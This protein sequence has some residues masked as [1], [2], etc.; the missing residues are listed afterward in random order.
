MTYMELG[1]AERALLG[2]LDAIDTTRVDVDLFINQHTGELM[3]L[4]PSKIN[5]LPE[6]AEYSCIRRSWKAI[7][8]EGHYKM[9]VLKVLNAIKWKFY[10]KKNHIK[11]DGVST[12]FSMDTMIKYLPSLYYLGEYDLAI[13]FIDPPHIIQD[14]VLA[15]K[16]IEWIHTDFTAF[17]YNSS[18]T[19]SRWAANDYI[20]SISPDI[21]KSFLTLYPTLKDKI[22]EIENILSINSVHKQAEQFVVNKEIISSASRKDCLN[23]LSIGRFCYPKNF[24]N[25]PDIARR[26]IRMGY[27]N[28]HWYLIGFGP[29]ER[30]IRQKIKDTGM[31]EHVIILGK[32]ENPYP[33]IK[34]CDIYVQPSRY[35]GKSV[36]V[37]EAQVLC[38]PVI[39]TRYPTSASQ[40][41]D[42]EDGIICDLD[43]QEIAKAIYSLAKNK[44][45]MEKIS[46]YLSTHN[47]GNQNEINKI[48]NLMEI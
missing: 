13:S 14:K 2:F 45:M 40:V 25:I 11:R 17:N 28:L 23:I 12:H 38:K 18:L 10:L 3:S 41:K 33:Y 8:R 19:Y 35:E 43:N 22:I 34:A 36:T 48:Y 21:T 4:I 7:L 47:Y 32:K 20:A 31:Q 26:I 30:L 27:T 9:A 5:L 6:I 15:K 42:G 37:R 46:F 24:E 44:K 1:G 29:D 39:I 16:R